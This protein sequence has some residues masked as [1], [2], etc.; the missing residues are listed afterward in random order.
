[1]FIEDVEN[2]IPESNIVCVSPHY[3][4]FLFFLGAY[5]LGMKAKG[6][7][8][9]KRFTNINTCSRTNYQERDIEGNKDRSLPRVQYAT[10]V[11][12]IEDLECLDDLLGP[13]NYYYRVLGEEESQVRGKAFNEG[14]G[15]MEMAYGS[16]ETMDESDWSI[17]RN[18]EAC[19][20]ELMALEDTAIVL[21][22]SMKGHI[23]HFVVREGGVR[24]MLSGSGAATFYFAEDKPY[25]GI[26][27]EEESGITDRFIAE[28]GLSDIAF[29]HFPGEIIRLAYKHY[30]SQVD[31]IYDEGVLNRNDQLKEVYG[32]ATD[33]DR[34][35]RYDRQ[36]E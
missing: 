29:P 1:M 34:I 22:L 13:R 2:V 25:A 35:F 18:V 26:M 10:G 30:P 33:C 15:E 31:D 32:V 11:R 21:P 12:F 19:V 9:T 23:D 27:T 20:R 17:V 7:L 5:V 8:G 4:D 3:D 24:A 6:L 14:E 28:Y 36:A 16:L